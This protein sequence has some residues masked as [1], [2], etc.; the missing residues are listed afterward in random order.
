MT[1]SGFSGLMGIKFIWYTTAG[2]AALIVTTRIIIKQQSGVTQWEA[3]RG[4]K[5]GVGQ[6]MVW[7]AQRIK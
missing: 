1:R 5:I 3:V 6:N 7:G 4:N 2:R